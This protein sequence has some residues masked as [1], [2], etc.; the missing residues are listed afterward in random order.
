MMTVA[1]A[2]VGGVILGVALNVSMLL[3][4]LSPLWLL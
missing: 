4:Y 3:K 2:V 1:L